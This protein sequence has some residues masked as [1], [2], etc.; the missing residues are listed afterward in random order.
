IGPLIKELV[1][2]HPIDPFGFKSECIYRV[3]V[4]VD[5]LSNARTIPKILKIA[6]EHAQ[7]RRIFK[8]PDTIEDIELILLNLWFYIGRHR[9][10]MR[11][12]IVQIYRYSFYTVNYNPAR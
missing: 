7:P 9:R 8:I 2:N 12:A 10:V 3:K 4:Q 1:R 5:T 11:P 6:I